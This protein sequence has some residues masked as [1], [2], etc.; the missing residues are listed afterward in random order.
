MND[1]FVNEVRKFRHEH[2]QQFHGDLT[3]ICE[4]LREIQRTC[5]QPVVT[6]SPKRL[7]KRSHTQQN[8]EDGEQVAA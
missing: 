3:A 5:G 4:D 8:A 1:P 6:F 2:A 7:P